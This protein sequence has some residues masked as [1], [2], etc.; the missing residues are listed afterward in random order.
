MEL[1]TLG[2]GSGYT[3]QDVQQLA[4]ILTG[5]GLVPLDGKEQKFPPALAPFVVREGL[6]QFN[7]KRHDF[8][9]K[10]LLGQPIK[11]SGFEEVTQL[12][13]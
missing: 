4:L 3:Q 12:S 7:P 1:H 9:D 6:F 8:S 13:S 5:S 11:G 10:V 2:V